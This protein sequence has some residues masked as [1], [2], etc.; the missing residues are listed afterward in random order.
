MNIAEVISQIYNIS[1]AKPIIKKLKIKSKQYFKQL[2]T[3]R[4]SFIEN[5][6]YDPCLEE[7]TSL[8][9]AFKVNTDAMITHGHDMKR[10]KSILDDNNQ[11]E[12][13]IARVIAF[14]RTS[15]YR[16]QLQQIGSRHSI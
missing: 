16:Y 13:Y 4:Q 12:K 9:Y 11:L 1:R 2:H 10:R 7:L 5:D 8:I 14:C 6:Y 3:I 15:L